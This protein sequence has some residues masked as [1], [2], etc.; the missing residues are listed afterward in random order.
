MISDNF[1]FLFAKQTNPRNYAAYNNMK[2]GGNAQRI[3]QGMLTKRE[4]SV[5]L[6]SK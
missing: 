3:R 1:C 6:T 5:Q 2:V 4:S